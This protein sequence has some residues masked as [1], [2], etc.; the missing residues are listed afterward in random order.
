VKV[1]TER[2]DE[3]KLKVGSLDYGM[4]LKLVCWQQHC[5]HYTIYPPKTMISVE[6]FHKF[7]IV[8]IIFT[9]LHF[10][11]LYTIMQPLN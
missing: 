4:T 5:M 7:F 3:A 11:T 6:P 1:L 2:R 10:M 9:K 8:A